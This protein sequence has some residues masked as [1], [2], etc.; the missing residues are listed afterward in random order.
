MIN[1]KG[2]LVPVDIGLFLRGEGIK[3]G[4]VFVENSAF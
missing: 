2:G 1:V 3:M 4:F